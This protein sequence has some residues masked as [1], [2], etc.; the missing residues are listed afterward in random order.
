MPYRKSNTQY[1]SELFELYGDKITYNNI[2]YCGIKSIVSFEC[3]FCGS[4]YSRN[5]RKLLLG[6]FKCKSCSLKNIYKENF[7]VF[8]EK[9]NKKYNYKYDYSESVYKSTD[10][11][12]KIKCPK[13]GYFYQTPYKHLSLKYGCPACANDF[14]KKTGLLNKET[15]IER[16]KKTHGEKYDY[17]KVEYNGVFEKVEIICPIHGSF[18]QTPKNHISGNKC[19]KCTKHVS[20]ISKQWL[21][22]ISDKLILEYMLPENKNLIVDGYDPETNTVYQFHGDYWHGNPDVYDPNKIHGH[23]KETYGQLYEKTKAIDSEIQEYGYNLVIMW[24]SDYRNSYS[25]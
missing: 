16:F 5:A 15:I 12:I 14:N 24:E 8:L 21:D 6:K 9:A 10:V 13:H 2:H 3:T 1:K 18:F 22:S 4:R 20:N 23:R 19:K 25:R 17:S 7:K 11:K